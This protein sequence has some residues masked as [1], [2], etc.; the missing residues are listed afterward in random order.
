M[1]FLKDTAEEQVCQAT[2]MHVVSEKT[3]CVSLELQ[4]SRGI[5]DRKRLPRIR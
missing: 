1:R 2:K 3:E 5:H 4:V